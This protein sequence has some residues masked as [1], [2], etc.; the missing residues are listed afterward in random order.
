MERIHIER[1]RMTPGK[2]PASNTPRRSLQ[3]TSAAKLLTKALKVATMPQQKTSPARYRAGCSLLMIMF[4]G[5]SKIL[6]V[7]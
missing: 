2:R 7:G 5:V 6:T 3:A 4:E 1:Y